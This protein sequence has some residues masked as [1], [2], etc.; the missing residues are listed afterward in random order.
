MEHG[1]QWK[2]TIK[3]GVEGLRFRLVSLHLKS[4]FACE[5]LTISGNW[6]ILRGEVPPESASPQIDAKASEYRK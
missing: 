4:V 6:L 1:P 5:L 2:D 3:D